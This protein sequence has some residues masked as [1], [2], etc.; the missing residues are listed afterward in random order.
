MRVTL[1][2]APSSLEVSE[3]AAAICV[4]KTHNPSPTGLKHA[5]ESGHLSVLEHISFTFLVEDVS[6]ALTH[7]LVRHRI[8]SYSQQSQRY[9]KVATNTDWYVI[10]ESIKDSDVLH[11]YRK[12]MDN[13]ARSYDKLLQF[14]PK[15]DARYVLPNACFTS[16]IVTVNARAFIEQAEKR[17]CNRAQW[18]IRN[19][20]RKMLRLIK[21]QLPEI[22]EMCKPP[23]KKGGCKES[24][25]CGIS[26]DE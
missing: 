25:P 8:A 4:G 19:M 13:I 21:T 15:E 11:E 6:R 18:E 3:K 20:Y 12:C 9:C 17:L 16:I 2:Q 14:I 1:L 23:C 10:P 24:K 26:W 7:Q 22:A 5:L